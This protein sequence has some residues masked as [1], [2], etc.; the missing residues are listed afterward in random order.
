MRT[1]SGVSAAIRALSRGTR[2][3]E[4]VLGPAV[5]PFGHR[6]MGTCRPADTGDGHRRRTTGAARPTAKPASPRG[7]AGMRASRSCTPTPET[8]AGAS[9]RRSW[10]GRERR[11]RRP[12]RRRAASVSPAPD[13]GRS[14]RRRRRVVPVG[15]LARKRGGADVRNGRQ[16]RRSLRAEQRPAPRARSPTDRHSSRRTPPPLARR[17]A[18]AA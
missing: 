16:A 4:Q 10:A 14:R 7:S 12:R 3:Y 9:G 1:A 6:T 13:Q 2:L 11:R 17:R 8:G 15:G 18:E 5:G